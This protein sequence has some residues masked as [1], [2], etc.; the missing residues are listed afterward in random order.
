MAQRV[1][2]LPEQRS[3]MFE[4]SRGGAA[5]VLCRGSSQLQLGRGQLL[6]CAVMQVSRERLGGAVDCGR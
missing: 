5:L 1:F 3:H 6:Q 4:A 2:D